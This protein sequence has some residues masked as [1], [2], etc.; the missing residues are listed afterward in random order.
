LRVEEDLSVSHPLAYGPLQV[1]GGEFGEVAF[2]DEHAAAGVVDVEERLEIAEHVRAA[3]RVDVGE[4]Q[5]DT[6]AAR[7]LEHDVRLKG[8]FDVEVKFGFRERDEAGLEG[9][10]SVGHAGKVARH[11][12]DGDERTRPARLL[13]GRGA[14]RG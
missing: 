9:I 13:L 3:D 8:A 6:V 12:V 10:V 14:P 1:R 4:R 5:R 11:L 7:E 2:G